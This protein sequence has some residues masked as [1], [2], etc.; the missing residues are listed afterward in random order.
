MKTACIGA[1][2]WSYKQWLGKLYPRELKPEGYLKEYSKHFNSVELNNT[3]Y[4]IPSIKTVENWREQTPDDF[5]F[6]AK[7]PRSISHSKTIGGDDEKL[8]VFLRN[9]SHLEE[10]LGPI[11]LQ[12]PPTLQEETEN[13]AQ[14]FSKIPDNPRY[15]VEF[16][17]TTW[18]TPQVFNIL[19]ENDTALVVVDHPWLPELDEITADFTYIRWQGDRNT[20]TGYRGVVEVY[21][22]ENT[23]RWSNK[24]REVL[25]SIKVYGYFSK[26]YSGYPPQDIKDLRLTV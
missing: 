14:F 5:I 20:V 16:R 6:A 10:K 8:E 4:R 3:F 13:L 7:F 25:E 1:M 18:F 22:K 24:I 19:R 17:H 15:A 2:G 11:L 21:R 12:L 23:Q 9:I 26:H